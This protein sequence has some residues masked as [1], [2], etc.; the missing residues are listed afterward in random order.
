MEQ[1]WYFEK[2]G[3]AGSA[4]GG[5]QNNIIDRFDTLLHHEIRFPL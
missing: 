3:H 1:T 5:N 2:Y 4:P